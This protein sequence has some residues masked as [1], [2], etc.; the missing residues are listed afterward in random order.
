M[1]GG[2]E[3]VAH[4]SGIEKAVAGLILVACAFYCFHALGLN[5]GSLSNPRS[6]FMP[7]VIGVSATVL[8]AVNL[9]LTLRKHR[10]AEADEVA[11]DRYTALNLLM[12]L[13][14]TIAFLVLLDLAGYVVAS[15]LYLLFLTK[16]TR[17]PGWLVP[18]A[19][20]IGATGFFYFCFVM[21]LGVTLP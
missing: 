15:A 19:V 10:M 16:L 20:S 2:T 18:M 12:A 17:S 1:A 14:G 7:S 21:L 4:R 5:F 13:A 3:I 9:V 11:L 8:A 6:G